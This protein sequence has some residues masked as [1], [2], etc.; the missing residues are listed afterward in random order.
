MQIGLQGFVYCIMVAQILK[1]NT[2]L[3]NQQN[4]YSKYI[5]IVCLKLYQNK[6]RKILTEKLR[7][8]SSL[9]DLN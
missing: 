1:K 4:I 7:L 9:S 2:K 5:I 6:K 3:L 8:Q